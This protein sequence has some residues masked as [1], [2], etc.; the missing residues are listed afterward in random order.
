MKF[1]PSD[2]VKF[3]IVAI[4]DRELGAVGRPFGRLLES[5]F[6]TEK[7]RDSL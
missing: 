2:L 7:M 1:L 3:V 4:L 6:Q 5:F